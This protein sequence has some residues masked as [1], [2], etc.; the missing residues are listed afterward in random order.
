MKIVDGIRK[1]Y[2]ENLNIR[3]PL[4]S[5]RVTLTGHLLFVHDRTR[6]F[7]VGKRKAPRRNHRLIHCVS[8]WKIPIRQETFV[9]QIVLEYRELAVELSRH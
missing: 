7:P 6:M 2:R 1:G 9:E 4:F 8:A 3:Y 5:S